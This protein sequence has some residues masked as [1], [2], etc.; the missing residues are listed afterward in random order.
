[1]EDNKK[2]AYKVLI[3]QAFLDIKNSRNHN[4]A[5]HIAHA[6]HNLADLLTK[7]FEGMDEV[8]FWE[9]IS[10]LD[11]KFGLNH[12]RGLFDSTLANDR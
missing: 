3:Y 7:D 5:F 10:F 11:K 6:F 4:V 9:R 12:Y 8:D 2:N 1:M